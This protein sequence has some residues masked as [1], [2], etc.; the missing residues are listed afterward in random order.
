MR[1]LSAISALIFFAAIF[2]LVS[3]AQEA[4]SW[5]VR[6]L[7]Q[8]IPGA[9]VASVDMEGDTVTGTN[10]IFVQYGGTVLMADSVSVNRQ[11]G[12]AVADG[13]VRIEQQGGQIWIGEHITYNFKTHQM[14]SDQF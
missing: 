3:V 7:N 1:N 4:P 2:P 14:R 9:P 10:G 13:H 5:D 12:E 8:I 11:S 6:G